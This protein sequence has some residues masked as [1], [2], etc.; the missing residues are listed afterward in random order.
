MAK[1]F[2]RQS[3][4]LQQRG[5]FE[6]AYVY[7]SPAMPA[8]VDLPDD[9]KPSKDMTPIDAP[10]PEKP[11]PAHATTGKTPPQ[12]AAEKFSKPEGGPGGRLADR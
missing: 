2:M 8:Q 10:Q 11:L 12:K 7:A 4:F 3:R 5:Q 9:V 1:Y 6:P